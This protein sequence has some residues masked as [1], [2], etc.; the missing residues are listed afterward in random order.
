MDFSTLKIRQTGYIGEAAV[1]SGALILGAMAGALAAKYAGASALEETAA[2]VAG[3]AGGTFFSAAVRVFRLP[4]LICL[5]ACGVFGV[6]L[7]P[8][9]LAARGFLMSY[10]V[11]VLVRCFS[12]A[13]FWTG[14]AAYAVYNL[15]VLPCV[16]FMSIYG[17]AISRYIA[18]CVFGRG[19]AS[20]PE[21]GVLSKALICF[22][23]I[24]C[25]SVLEYWV[26]PILLSM[27]NN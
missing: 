9:L 15:I 3:G 24:A 4:L 6:F 16:M 27:V 14:A 2:Y 7:I 8:A 23:A 11:A 17:M 25:A 5:C 10:S 20:S 26:T 18:G 22:A 21:S 1:C 19:G 13:G 12:V